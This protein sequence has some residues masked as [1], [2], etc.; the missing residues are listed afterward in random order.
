[1]GFQG[2]LHTL[3]MLRRS[4][5]TQGTSSSPLCMAHRGHC[6]ES[7]ERESGNDTAQHQMLPRTSGPMQPNSYCSRDTHNRVPRPT[8]RWLLK[9]FMKESLQPLW[10]LLGSCVTKH[11]LLLE[12]GKKNPKNQFDIQSVALWYSLPHSLFKGVFLILMAVE[13]L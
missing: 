8:S 11:I 10:A 9:I 13:H 1:M 5:V 12:K 6:M 2:N 3:Q 7:V 4:R